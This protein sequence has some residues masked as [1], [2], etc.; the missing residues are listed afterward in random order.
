MRRNTNRQPDHEQLVAAAIAAAFEEGLHAVSLESVAARCD[1]PLKVVE[2]LQPDVNP[3]VAE[4][5]SRIVSAELAEVKRV[6]LAHPSPVRQLWALLETLAEPVRAEVD[7]VWLESWSLGRRNAEL[8]AA[9]REQ[10]SAWHVL[11]AAVVRR[12]VKSGDFLPVDADDVAA[13]I[14]A[15]I[16]GVNAYALVGYRSDLDRMRLLTSIA[17]AEL[18]ARFED[19]VHTPA[20]SPTLAV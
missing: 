14:L 5:F 20:P 18:G 19:V 7:S 12:G 3:L 6:V 11:V 17:R 15:M 4:A 1:V 9:V 16:D 2:R 8:G 10:E 13:Q